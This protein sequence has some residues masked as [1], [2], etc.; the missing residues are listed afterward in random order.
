MRPLPCAL[1]LAETHHS[2]GNADQASA[3]RGS[4]SVA[5]IVS[6]SY[7][8]TIHVSLR[9]EPEERPNARKAYFRR[10]PHR[11]DLSAAWPVV[12]AGPQQ[13]EIARA[14]RRGDG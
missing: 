5:L 10:Q 9:S 2:H 8:V 13:V 3:R 12:V 7:D 11:P 6:R 14:A 1:P 4:L